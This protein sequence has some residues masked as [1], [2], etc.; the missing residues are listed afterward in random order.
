MN[1]VQEK[2]Q[3]QAYPVIREVPGKA[4]DFIII[5]EQGQSNQLTFPYETK[6]GACSIR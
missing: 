4:L 5:D 6:T 1:S 3:G 2:M